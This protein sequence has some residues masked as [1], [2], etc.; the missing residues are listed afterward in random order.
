[1]TIL[2][3]AMLCIAN[4]QGARE[5]TYCQ[6]Q[7]ALTLQGARLPDG[8]LLPYNDTWREVFINLRCCSQNSIERS[9]ANAE[10]R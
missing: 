4:L 1:M 10:R 6:L 9:D 8:T 2:R 5:M 3:D 7:E